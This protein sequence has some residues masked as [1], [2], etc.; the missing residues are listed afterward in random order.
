ML[1]HIHKKVQKASKPTV[2]WLG[3]IYFLMKHKSFDLNNNKA[4]LYYTY[5]TMQI[6]FPRTEPDMHDEI[7]DEEV[8]K[9]LI[10]P[11]QCSLLSL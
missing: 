1:K 7:I 10:S 9:F 6:S 3:F 5:D 11:F 4:V 2:L 8:L